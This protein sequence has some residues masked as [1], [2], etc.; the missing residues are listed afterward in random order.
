VTEIQSN[1]VRQPPRHLSA[2]SK[3]FFR[4]VV[5]SFDM[6]DHHFSLLTLALEAWD[7]GQQAREALRAAGSLTF[8]DRFGQPHARPEVN[9]ERDARLSYARL[10]REIG[11]DAAGTPEIARPVLLRANQGGKQHARKA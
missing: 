8:V 9:I 11:L 3:R 2:A 1:G 10:L 7:Q 5:G 4:A 6:E